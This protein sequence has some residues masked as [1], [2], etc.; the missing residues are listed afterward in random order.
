MFSGWPGHVKT[1]QMKKHTK[2][3]LNRALLMEFKKLDEFTN[4]L[5]VTLRR[6]SSKTN[7]N[8]YDYTNTRS[9]SYLKANV[10][11]TAARERFCKHSSGLNFA[12]QA[13]IL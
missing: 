7:N 12:F 2:Q 5:T 11:C 13:R 3:N 8:A 6:I 4:N 1:N 9:K 10:L